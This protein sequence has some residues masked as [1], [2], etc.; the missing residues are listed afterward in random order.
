MTRILS[1]L[2][3][4]LLLPVVGHS[5]DDQRWGVEA[6][7]GK[8]LKLS[9]NYRENSKKIKVAE[10]N[11]TYVATTKKVLCKYFNTHKPIPF[12]NQNT[13]KFFTSKKD[14]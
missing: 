8:A 12:A 11:P 1:F 2:M 10:H 6:E 13:L 14:I 7:N 5:S 3:L 9:N 4:S